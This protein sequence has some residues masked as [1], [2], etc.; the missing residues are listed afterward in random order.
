VLT[1]PVL[2]NIGIVHP[3]PGFHDSLRE[4]TTANGALLIVDEAA[5]TIA[6]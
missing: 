2:T 5:R 3:Q 6:A 4:L 1:E